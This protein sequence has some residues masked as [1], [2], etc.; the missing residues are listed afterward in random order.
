MTVEAIKGSRQQVLSGSSREATVMMDIWEAEPRLASQG[1]RPA[2]RM[3]GRAQSSGWRDEVRGCNPLLRGNAL[4]KGA[5]AV[6]V[7]VRKIRSG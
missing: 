4:Q 1:L 3:I 7:E 2:G 6:R 5:L